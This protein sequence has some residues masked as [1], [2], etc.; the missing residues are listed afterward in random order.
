MSVFANKANG[1]LFF[2]QT[3]AQCVYKKSK[4]VLVYGGGVCFFETGNNDF[5]SIMH[6]KSF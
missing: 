3:L 5:F 1:N 2:E 6:K 4:C